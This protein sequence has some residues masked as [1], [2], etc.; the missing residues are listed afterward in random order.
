M[1]RN[2]GLLC[3]VAFSNSPPCSR[4]PIVESCDRLDLAASALSA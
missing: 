1:T 4:T 3:G 2:T